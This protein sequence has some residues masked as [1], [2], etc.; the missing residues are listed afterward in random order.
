VKKDQ[1]L[2]MASTKL[3]TPLDIILGG[4]DN[5]LAKALLQWSRPLQ[6][7]PFV[8]FFR[9]NLPQDSAPAMGILTLH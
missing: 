9:N 6:H 5:E 2:E 4:H 1:E 3:R 7:V 8:S